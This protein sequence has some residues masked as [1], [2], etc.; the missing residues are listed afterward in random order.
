MRIT[1]GDI[2]SFGYNHLI[3]NQQKFPL[4]IN[5]HFLILLLIPNFRLMS[6]QKRCD[7]RYL[8]QVLKFCQVSF[9]HMEASCQPRESGVSPERAVFLI[10]VRNLHNVE[11]RKVI[12]FFKKVYFVPLYMLNSFTRLLASILILTRWHLPALSILY[13]YQHIGTGASWSSSL[14]CQGSRYYALSP[15]RFVRTTYGRRKEQ[16]SRLNM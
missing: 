4:F 11:F 13:G 9:K 7:S 5:L 2:Y 6:T 14:G 15:Q 8:N 16:D 1:K 12:L 10:M 3:L